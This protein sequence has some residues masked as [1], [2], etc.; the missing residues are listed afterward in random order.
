MHITFSRAEP[1]S[2]CKTLTAD[3]FDDIHIAMGDMSFTAP[4]NGGY[5]KCD[6]SVTFDN[7]EKNVYQGTYDLKHHSMGAPNLAQHIRDNILFY[8]GKSRPAHLSQ[9]QYDHYLAITF[10]DSESIKEV[11]ALADRLLPILETAIAAAKPI[12]YPTV[13]HV[14]HN[15]LGRFDATYAQNINVEIIHRNKSTAD[16]R[17]NPNIPE[18][19]KFGWDERVFL[20]VTDVERGE[21]V[22]AV[23]TDNIVEMFNL[24]ATELPWVFEG[25]ENEP[26]MLSDEERYK[27]WTKQQ[28]RSNPKLYGESDDEASERPSA[29][30]KP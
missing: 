24:I 1:S 13:S 21:I 9:K 23:E 19:M 11:N 2:L 30:A 17:D 8:T 3:S 15:G 18:Q 12:E 5:D 7:D 27:E 6:F 16:N 4:A 22:R 10:P 14:N 20:V 25:G 26:L 29:T 28:A